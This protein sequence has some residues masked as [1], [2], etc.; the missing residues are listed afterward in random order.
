MYYEEQLTPSPLATVKMVGASGVSEEA[1]NDILSQDECSD[2][3]Q[4]NSTD[5]SITHS[6]IVFSVQKTML[7]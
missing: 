1:L 5:V 6:F 7:N 2:G 3:H 4:M